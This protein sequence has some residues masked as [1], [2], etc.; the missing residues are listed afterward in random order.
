MKILT[1]SYGLASANMYVLL[2]GKEAIVIDPCCPWSETKLED[3]NVKAVFCTHGHFDHIFEADDIY[4][5]FKCPIYISEDD[6]V[7]L[8]DPILNHGVDFGL[9]VSVSAPSSVFP[10]TETDQRKLG[11]SD[12]EGF[13]LKIIPTPGHTS[14]SV[15]FLF[16]MEN[17][18]KHMFTGDMLFMRSIGRTDLGGSYSDMSRSIEL[19]KSMDDDIICYPGHGPKTI[20]G[21]EKKCNPYF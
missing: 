1:F 8:A 13:F 4:S 2:F 17:S 9:N 19:L 3:V 7:M 12:A 10:Y 20:L 5:H 15:C 6:Q 11:L 18:E 21:S 14:G 16:T